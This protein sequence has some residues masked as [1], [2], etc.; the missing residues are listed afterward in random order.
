MEVNEEERILSNEEQ[1]VEGL[2]EDCKEN[3]FEYQR[4]RDMLLF[5]KHDS[6]LELDANLLQV[7]EENQPFSK[8][9]GMGGCSEKACELLKCLSLGKA[10]V[11]HGPK[12]CGKTR[13]VNELLRKINNKNHRIL[14]VSSETDFTTL[15]GSIDTRG[16]FNEGVLYRAAQNGELVVFENAENMTTELIEMLDA[17]LDPFAS[18]FYYPTNGMIHPAFRCLFC[19][20]LRSSE[21]CRWTPFQRRGLESW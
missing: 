20:C 11:L 9:A 16:V 8:L 2:L 10:S 13:M 14:H 1:V 15:M 4:M 18:E 6:N 12:G 21:L 7:V 19:H 3:V 17:L 5:F